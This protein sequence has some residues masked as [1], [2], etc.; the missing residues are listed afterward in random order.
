M[1][2]SK[3]D[4]LKEY[5]DEV[6]SKKITNMFEGGS[7]KYNQSWR[8]SLLEAHVNSLIGAPIAILS[9]VGLLL[10]AGIVVTW[11][12]ALVFATAAWPVFFY[13]SVGRIFLF[14]R[15]FEKYGF[16]LE[17]LEIFRKMK[18]LY[19]DLRGKSNEDKEG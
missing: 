8:A 16:S 17:P 4:A 11:E 6:M 2:E 12:N 10:W 5:E 7:V 13:L 1:E 19:G 9:H 3:K 14:R 15:I 18:R